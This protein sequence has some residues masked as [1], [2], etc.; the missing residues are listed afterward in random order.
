MA[1]SD[2]RSV[3][4]GAGVAENLSRATAVGSPVQTAVLRG[5]IKSPRGEASQVRPGLHFSLP[6]AIGLEWRSDNI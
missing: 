4:P 1:E 6:D 5:A 3:S 2:A